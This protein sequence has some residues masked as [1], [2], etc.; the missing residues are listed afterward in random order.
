MVAAGLALSGGTVRVMDATGKVF[1]SGKPVSATGGYGPIT[2]TGGGPY[3][4]EACGSVAHKPLCLW[5]ATTLGG[6]LNLTPLTSALTVLAGGQGPEL[7]MNG[8]VKGLSDAALSSAQTQLRAAL[9]PVLAD[10]GLAADFDLLTGALTPASHTGYDRLLDQLELAFGTDTQAFVTLTPRLGTGQATLDANGT[11]GSLALD[12]AAANFDFAGIDSLYAAMNTA[13]ATVGSCQLGLTA[14]FDANARASVDS[15]TFANAGQSAQLLCLRLN[16]TLGAT[17]EVLFGGKLLPALIDRCDFGAGDPLCRVSFVFQNS[18]GLLRPLGIEQ[19]VVKRPSGWAFLGNR[20]E[21]QASAVA[22]LVRTQRV[23]NLAADLYARYLDIRIPYV[24]LNS[25]GDLQCARVS[26]KDSTGADLSLALYKRTGT[27]STADPLLSL[28]S[29][30]SS[31]ATPS[32]DPAAGTTRGAGAV[33]L[34][35]SGPSGDAVARNLTRVGRALKVEL[36]SDS[37]CSLPL[38]GA[39]GASLSINLAGSLPVSASSLNGQA[40]PQL[41][42]ASGTALAALKAAAA[43]KLS[44]SPIW[45]LSRGGSA[46]NRAQLCGDAACNLKLAELELAAGATTAALSGTLGPSAVNAADYKLLRLT[47]RTT[48]GLLLQLDATACTA[49]AIGLPCP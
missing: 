38:A 10:A 12:P 39:D 32:L 3:R 16:G 5:G 9:A 6:T 47:A 31:D 43:S 24:N 17:G 23:D 34:P 49:Q 41:T 21:V 2:L 15:L 20:L 4:V 35:L 44:Y 33:S 46:M 8:A 48:D 28:W 37:A 11:Q 36:F 14:L 7:L 30:S 19:A 27:A 40:W 22:R 25:A 13:M 18:K 26:Q 29:T 42:A 1:S 45:T